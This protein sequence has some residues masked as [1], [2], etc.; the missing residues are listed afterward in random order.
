MGKTNKREEFKMKLS[1]K[2]TAMAMVAVMALGVTACGGSEPAA[3]DVHTGCLWQ[4][5]RS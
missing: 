3:D 1:K 4:Q 2:L 5:G